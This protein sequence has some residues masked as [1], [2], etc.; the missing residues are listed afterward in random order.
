MTIT[1]LSFVLFLFGVFV[2]YYLLPKKWQW[3]L[4]LAAS[5]VFYAFGQIF[6]VLY[7]LLIALA[8]YGFACR[9]EHNTK[10]RKAYLKENKETLSSEEKTAYKAKS[11]QR[12]KV[13][14]V[15]AI[16]LVVAVLIVLKYLRQFFAVFFPD[17]ANGQLFARI[18]IPLGIS[19]VTLMA[20][21]YLTEVYWENYGAE[22]NYFRLLL[23]LSFFP[24][25]TQGPISDY[26]ALA[27]QLAAPHEADY[28]NISKGFQRLVW[29]L[30]KKMLIADVLSPY[31]AT[32]FSNYADYA[33]ISLLL[34]AVFYMIQL[35][36]DFSGYMDI[37]CGYC[38]M[39][40]IRLA[41]NFKT[42]FFS[43]SVSEF[44]RRWH[45]TLGEWLRKYIYYPIGLSDW[46]MS[47]SKKQNG[48]LKKLPTVIAIA[49]VWLVTGLWHGL[50]GTFILWG[51][52][53]GVIIIASTLLDPVYAQ[54]RSK[55]KIRD[56]SKLFHAFQIVRTFFLITF[57]E[58]IAASGSVRAGIRYIV[59]M[60][61]VHTVP[62]SVK[63]LVPFI[64]LATNFS[65]INL[66]LAAVGV[67]ILV[68][69]SCIEQKEPVRNRFNKLPLVLRLVILSGAILLVASFGVQS[70]WNAE[71]F[72]YA[73][74]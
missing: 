70:S 12:R 31:I 54:V 56:T 58:L 29:G 18:I 40:G 34:G 20:I 17:A 19:Y 39:L 3:I 64:N 65:L 57:S 8:V 73:N 9:L 48:F 26:E 13:I 30:F 61:T 42:P 46:G 28:Q 53:N 71:G 49:A 67:V 25:I 7:I 38:E 60:F 37:M 10:T 72:M 66:A 41:E 21:G 47:L 1:S 68:V 22:K 44:W 74:F 33:G 43:R 6:S 59:R 45:I 27:P 52:I 16:V 15:C 2:L 69:F 4:L 55:L 24:H 36:A 32:L 62:T 5:I 50:N 11:K 51:A 63:G 23:F 14:Y 35:Y